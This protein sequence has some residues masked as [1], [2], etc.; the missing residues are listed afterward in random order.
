MG[1]KEEIGS[2][3]G[4]LF[5]VLECF[6][7]YWEVRICNTISLTVTKSRFRSA[8]KV[9]C[10]EKFTYGSLYTS[11]VQTNQNVVLMDIWIDIHP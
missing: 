10:S 1:K 7:G 5:F 11:F 8:R 6:S 2:G 3:Y 4:F 9:H